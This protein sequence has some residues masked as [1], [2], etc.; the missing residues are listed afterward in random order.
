MPKT[1]KQKRVATDLMEIAMII[2]VAASTFVDE[3]SDPLS[4]VG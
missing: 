3:L 4:V 2:V 1:N